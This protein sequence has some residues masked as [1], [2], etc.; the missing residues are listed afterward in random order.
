[1]L[2]KFYRTSARHSYCPTFG[3]GYPLDMLREFAT[4]VP[5]SPD[6]SGILLSRFAKRVKDIADSGISFP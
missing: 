2:F 4:L 6:G 5:N 1:M 3:L